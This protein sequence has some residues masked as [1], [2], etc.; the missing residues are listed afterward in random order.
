[1]D[2]APTSTSTSVNARQPLPARTDQQ[3]G[4]TSGLGSRPLAGFTC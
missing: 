3:G 2:M 1:M 4:E